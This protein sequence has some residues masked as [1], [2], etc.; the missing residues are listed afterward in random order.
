[1]HSIA[2]GNMTHDEIRYHMPAQ[3]GCP[4]GRCCCACSR[5]TS[6]CCRSKSRAAR[7]LCIRFAGYPPHLR[8]RC[9]RDGA[10][11]KAG[12][13]ALRRRAQV[14]C[15]RARDSVVA[16]QRA[17][18]QHVRPHREDILR[19]QQVIL[20]RVQGSTT[21]VRAL[22]APQLDGDKANRFLRFS[23][24]ASDPGKDKGRDKGSPAQEK[25]QRLPKQGRAMRGLAL[26]RR[27]GSKTGQN[28]RMRGGIVHSLH[29]DIIAEPS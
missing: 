9:A 3:S 25:C 22:T 14:F 21:H 10:R 27:L 13:Q 4:R 11:L 20:R 16:V 15:D 23:V 2:L 1:M 12:E 19:R 29:T 6:G 5:S 24:V 8:Q 28:V 18:V 26:R 7:L 17:L